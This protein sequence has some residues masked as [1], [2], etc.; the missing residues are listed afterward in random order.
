MRGAQHVSPRDGEVQHSTTRRGEG[1]PSRVS[2]WQPL[3]RPHCTETAAHPA[4]RSAGALTET[5]RLRK[6]RAQRT[7]RPSGVTSTACV[8]MRTPLS[9]SAS[10]ETRPG[11]IAACTTVCRVT[12]VWCANVS[13]GGTGCARVRRA[14]AGR[15]L[16]E[17]AALCLTAACPLRM[18]NAV[19]ASVTSLA[20]A[21]LLCRATL[22]ASARTCA[23][24]C[25]AARSARCR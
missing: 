15:R 21:R 23:A 17:H 18:V 16:R 19:S 5:V 9:V 4:R 13:P 7:C 20:R 6:S 14:P 3:P 24:V 11:D 1:A 8:V 12:R 10:P 2:K 22:H 25:R